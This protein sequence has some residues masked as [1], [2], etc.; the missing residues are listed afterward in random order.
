LL[1]GNPNAIF[2]NME[3]GEEKFIEYIMAMPSKL[4]VEIHKAE[5]GGFWAKIKN[6]PGCYT[7]AENFIEL[8]QMVND[9]VFTY[10]DIPLK[11]RRRLGYYI[12]MKIK[13]LLEQKSRHKQIEDAVQKIIA[14]KR[15][16][17]EFSK[18]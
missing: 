12:P 17:L 1:K 5:E 7:Q 6:L 10:F 2:K 14:G 13:I 4:E 15:K 16:T 11:Y 3:K 18:N 8:I 9:S